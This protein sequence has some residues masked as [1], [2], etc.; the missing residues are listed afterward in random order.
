MSQQALE[1]VIGR[2]IMDE[3]YRLLLFSDPNAALGDYDLTDAEMT[4]LRSVDA[5][6]LDACAHNIGRQVALSFRARRPPHVDL[7]SS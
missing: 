2:A 4:A 6:S 5:E 3:E 1:A 7:D